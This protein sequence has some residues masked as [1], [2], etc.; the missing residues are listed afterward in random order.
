M[1]LPLTE[2]FAVELLTKV[3]ED[4]GAREDLL[5]L[6]SFTS[7]DAALPE[8]RPGS[9]EAKSWALRLWWR[10]LYKPLIGDF[11]E[12]VIDRHNRFW[13]ERAKPLSE[14]EAK[15]IREGVRV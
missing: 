6:I 8:G 10:I 7:D 14:V 9:R 5:N 2:D 3:L 12:A 4:K 1:K 11:M 13:V 15:K